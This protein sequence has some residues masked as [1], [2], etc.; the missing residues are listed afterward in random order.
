MVPKYLM[1]AVTE[2]ILSVRQRRW[3]LPVVLFGIAFLL[4]FTSVPV[5]VFLKAGVWRRLR[6][7]L[8]P[9]NHNSVASIMMPIGGVLVLFVVSAV[10]VELV[11][12]L[13]KVYHEHKYEK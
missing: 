3:W 13:S 5:I 10:V 8:S 12:Q 4:L 9:F 2:T 11:R 1:T 6:Y 7:E